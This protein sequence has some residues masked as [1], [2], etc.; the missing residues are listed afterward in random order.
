ML[1]DHSAA[2]W[3]KL[4]SGF[5]VSEFGI[6]VRSEQSSMLFTSAEMMV[7]NTTMSCDP[8]QG[9]CTQSTPVDVK[10]LTALPAPAPSGGY[11]C[12]D[13][14]LRDVQFEVN[15]DTLP[16]EEVWVTGNSTELGRWNVE[17]AIELNSTSTEEDGVWKGAGLELQ[18]RT[19]FEYKF[20]RISADESVLWECGE[21]RLFVV[22]EECE[23]I[24][25]NAPN[26]FRCGQ[27]FS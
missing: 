11:G 22:G 17:H 16:G 25:G 27:R 4:A 14:S 1:N 7:S 21:N 6:T 15:A 9:Y 20:L 8:N 10:V 23:Q 19:A 3:F 26:L 2:F 18:P 24:V 5:D 12:R 13:S